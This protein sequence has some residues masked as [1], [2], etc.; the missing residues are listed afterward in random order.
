MKGNMENDDAARTSVSSEGRNSQRSLMDML[1]EATWRLESMEISSR[2]LLSGGGD[3]LNNNSDAAGVPPSLRADSS[4]RNQLEILQAQVAQLKTQLLL[5][6]SRREEENQI[7]RQA[8]QYAA[9][10]STAN[11]VLHALFDQASA[12][13]HAAL[14]KWLD[15]G[16]IATRDGLRHWKLDLRTLRNEAGATLLHVAV[17]VSMALPKLKLQLVRLLV[18][19]VGFDPNVRDVSFLLQKRR[20][21][22]LALR[23]MW[24]LA[25]VPTAK[26]EDSVPFDE[27]LR[28]R[29]PL[30]FDD[31]ICQVARLDTLF[32]DTI[33]WDPTFINELKVEVDGYALS[34]IA[35]ALTTEALVGPTWVGA[36]IK[37]IQCLKVKM[38][39]SVNSS[40]E[41][42][43]EMKTETGDVATVPVSPGDTDAPMMDAPTT[44][45]IAPPPRKLSTSSSISSAT[46]P[47]SPLYYADHNVANTRQA[48][49][50]AVLFK[51]STHTFPGTLT[52]TKGSN[53][54]IS[55]EDVAT[56]FPLGDRLTIGSTE[57]FAVEYDPENRQILLDHE[58]EEKDA[59]NVKAFV[60]GTCSSVLPPYITA[61]RIWEREPGNKFEDQMSNEQLFQDYQFLDPESD[62][63]VAIK[64]GPM[65]NARDARAIV[66]E[67]KQATKKLFDSNE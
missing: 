27:L 20:L 28:E 14:A 21:F 47:R 48:W 65:P 36:L 44:A 50:Y 60:S 32:Q 22:I 63:E 61:K 53:V 7:F 66:D 33:Y 17:D 6:V 1:G 57:Y 58:Y 4:S 9:A 54:A 10:K 55:S 24:L 59:A 51:A 52:V 13:K 46:D 42:D 23:L 34:L 8:M 38:A 49:Y 67:W 2:Q 15:T 5:T 12:G 31:S 30:L 41:A 11:G 43:M 16:S 35:P 40:A 18:D 56:C 25:I 64:L 37:M 3:A 19:R 26:Y 45:M 62:Y 29:V 39:E